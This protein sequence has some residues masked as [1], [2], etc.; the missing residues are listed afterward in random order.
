V[1]ASHRSTRTLLAGGASAGP[2]YITVGLGQILL[3]DGFDMRRHALSL[4]SNGAPGWIQIANFLL[5]G[6]LVIAGAIGVRRVLYPGRAGTWGPILLAGYGV[7]LIGAGIFVADPALGFPPGTALGGSTMS[8][9]GLLHFVFGAIGFYSLIAACLV[10]AR[11]FLG[12]GQRGWAAYSIVTALGFFIAFAAIASGPA[13]PAVMLS[14][15]AAIAWIWGW[16][17]LL[18]LRFIRLRES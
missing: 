10:F 9:H 12:E 17:T 3:R 15:Y 18:M 8:R 4:M 7:G 14:F 16:H 1:S 2:L 5:C 11:R 13:S 6:V